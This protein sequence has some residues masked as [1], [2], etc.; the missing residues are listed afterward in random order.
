MP[1]RSQTAKKRIGNVVR[2][3]NEFFAFGPDGRC[4]G[5][6]DTTIEAVRAIP[7][8]PAKENPNG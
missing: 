2:Q 1:S 4:I 5:V 7:A 8:I 3:G 6:F